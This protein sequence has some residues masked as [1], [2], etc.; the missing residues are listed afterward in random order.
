[1][2]TYRMDMYIRPGQMRNFNFILYFHVLCRVCVSVCLSFPHLICIMQ[3]NIQCQL[4]ID[5][6][7][8][9]LCRC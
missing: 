7:S 8:M 9:P 4:Q 3:Y 5:L 1:M 6:F 2:H